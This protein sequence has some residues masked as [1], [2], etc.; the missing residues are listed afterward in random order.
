MCSVGLKVLVCAKGNMFLEAMVKI[1]G[2]E[3][4]HL[5]NFFSKTPKMH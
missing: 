2:V 1:L 5:N 3:V 4:C